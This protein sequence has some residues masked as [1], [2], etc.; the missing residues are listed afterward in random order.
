MSTCCHSLHASASCHACM[1]ACARWHAGG[2]SSPSPALA[3]RTAQPPTQVAGGGLDEAHDS[4]EQVGLHR[5]V[6]AARGS[7]ATDGRPHGGQGCTQ[8][9][10]EGNVGCA[11]AVH[12]R[13][14]TACVPK[15]AG[16]WERGRL[17]VSM[18][19]GG[20]ACVRA[21]VRGLACTRGPPPSFPLPEPGGTSR[22][23]AQVGNPP[24]PPAPYL[25]P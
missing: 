10:G 9:E 8:G 21:N 18:R 2:P 4:A 24:F 20:R 19:A 14:H 1:R 3:A 6:P 12:A 15:K 5:H 25:R 7:R 23:S 13:T 22:P 16:R 11:G 17:H